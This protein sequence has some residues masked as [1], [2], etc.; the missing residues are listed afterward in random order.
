MFIIAMSFNNRMRLLLRGCPIGSG[1]ELSLL[2]T[3]SV[4][5]AKKIVS[6]CQARGGNEIVAAETISAW[7]RDAGQWS[8]GA[9]TRAT[10]QAMWLCWCLKGIWLLRNGKAISKIK[11]GVRSP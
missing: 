5:W 6:V 9:M 3:E 11:Q 8:A 7:D 2:I 4:V 1:D 10:A